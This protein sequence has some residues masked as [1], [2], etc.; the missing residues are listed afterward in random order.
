MKMPEEVKKAIDDMTPEQMDEAINM[1]SLIKREEAAIIKGT[2]NGD[3]PVDA[4]VAR[5]VAMAN[6]LSQ[7]RDAALLDKFE[8]RIINE[9]K[10]AVKALKTIH[11]I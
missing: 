1:A 3:N 11:G 8:A 10:N 6:L 5:V 9:I 7:A 4:M 2:I